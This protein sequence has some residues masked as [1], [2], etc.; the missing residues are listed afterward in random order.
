MQW[1]K[2]MLIYFQIVVVSLANQVSVLH[3]VVQEQQRE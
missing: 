1:T 3:H 2:K